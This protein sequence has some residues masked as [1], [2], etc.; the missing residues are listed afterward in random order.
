MDPLTAV[1]LAGNIINFVDFS[2]K[3]LSRARQLFES[4]SGATE[5][6]DELE[7]LT[8]NL[9]DFADR[10]RRRSSEISPRGHSRLSISSETVL[11]NLSQQC[12]QVAD[13]LLETLDSLKVKGDGR[14]RKSA[15]KAVKTVWK[16]DHIDALQRR[17]DRISKQ[18]MD[19]MSIEQ[20]EQINRRLREMAVENTHLEANR[21]KEIDQLRRDFNSAIEEIKA[22]LEEEHRPG[23]W[24]IL[25]DTARRGQAYFAEQVV[26]QS[27]R[28][29]SIDSRHQSISKE[30][31]HT[32]FQLGRYHE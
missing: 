20:L 12:I 21:S 9:K 8:K 27:L 3:A 14:T 28:F 5:E 13:E 17:L 22:N 29:S 23:A 7:S 2:A 30:H 24:L 32:F 18:L 6:N 1:G 26:L 19:A 10:T 31:S 16:K 4:A 25:S 15:I 11:D